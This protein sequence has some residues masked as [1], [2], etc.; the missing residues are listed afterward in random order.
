MRRDELNDLSAFVTIAEERNFTRAAAKLGMSPSALSHAMRTL[1][2]RHGVK[3]LARTTR[4]VA[5]TEAG[6]RLL[7][8]LRPAFEEIGA[9]LRT[10][11]GL[12]DKPAGTLRITTFRHAA[13]TVLWPVLPDFLAAYPDMRVE[14][15]VDDGLTDIVASRF[16]AGIR[17]G[18]KV[19]RDMIAVR[20]SPDIRSVVVGTPDYL[21][22]HPL[23]VTPQDLSRHRCIN[24]RMKTAGG[25][26]PWEFE[27][28]G[29]PL[30][31]RVEGPLILNDEEMILTAALAGQGLAL[32]YEDQVAR[33]LAAGRLVQV[34][35]DWCPAFPGYFLYY[36]SRRQVPPALTALVAALR[37]RLNVPAANR[38]L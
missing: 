30:Q 6:E 7:E 29:R 26:Y 17:W 5:P 32:L 11:D 36:S 34:L 27:K 38:R 3:L 25:L 23:P 31:V 22:T 14:I 28:D 13:T 35:A 9:G 33:H 21:A 8:A 37:A 18:E 10:L 2:T 24:Y 16:D 12:R 4:S 19:A 20:V 15:S 1:E